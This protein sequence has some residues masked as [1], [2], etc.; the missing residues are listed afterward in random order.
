VAP[1]RGRYALLDVGADMVEAPARTLMDEYALLQVHGIVRDFMHDLACMPAATHRRLV[2]F[3]GGH[4]E[5]PSEAAPRP[6]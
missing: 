5:S 1:T 4:R 6:G 2:L 3:L